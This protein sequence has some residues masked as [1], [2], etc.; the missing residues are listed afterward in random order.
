MFFSYFLITPIQY[1]NAYITYVNTM[2]TMYILKFIDFE[3]NI[4]FL[5]YY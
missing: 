5:F 4:F 3:S 2:Y 1:Y